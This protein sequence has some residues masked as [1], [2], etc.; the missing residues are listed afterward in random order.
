MLAQQDERGDPPIALFLDAFEILRFEPLFTQNRLAFLGRATQRLSVEA[1]DMPI[2]QQPRQL[3]RWVRARDRD[4]RDAFRHFLQSLRQRSAL[5]WRRSRLMNVVEYDDA[6]VWQRRKEIAEEAACELVQILLQLRCE[7]RQRG[8][9]FAPDLLR[10]DPHVMHEGRGIGIADV[11][12]V[13][14]VAQTAYLEIARDERGLARSGRSGQ[15]DNRPLRGVVE[16]R[17]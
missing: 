11:E 12:L 5:L 17:E 15:P 10:G 2:R 7:Q 9:R 1:H 14:D 6:G 4:D 13:P 16:E 8:S 3:W